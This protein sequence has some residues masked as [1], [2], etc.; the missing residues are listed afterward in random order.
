MSISLMPLNCVLNKLWFC[1]H[2]FGFWGHFFLFF[3]RVCLVFFVCCNLDVCCLRLFGCFFG[4]LLYSLSYSL[5]MLLFSLCVIMQPVSRLL[6]TETILL[7]PSLPQR[8][9]PILHQNWIQSLWPWSANDRLVRPNRS[10]SQG[11]DASTENQNHASTL[12]VITW[13]CKKNKLWITTLV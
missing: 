7:T 11:Q 13:R 9:T 5:E 10:Q 3:L 6:F 2:F 4:E 12:K 1:Y 8:F